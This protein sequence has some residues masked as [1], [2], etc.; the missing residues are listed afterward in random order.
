MDN[1]LPENFNHNYPLFSS[2]GDNSGEVL[3]S[4]QLIGSEN[5]SVWNSAMGIKILGRNKL[6][7]I[8]E[9]CKEGRFWP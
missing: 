7:F 6:G 1:T 5:Y 2:L 9:T 3:V 4:L 8:D